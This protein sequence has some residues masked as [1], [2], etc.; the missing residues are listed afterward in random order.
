MAF[1]ELPRLDASGDNTMIILHGLLGSSSNWRSVAV[2]LQ[3]R[4]RDNSI[5][6]FDLRNHGSSPHTPSMTVKD[7]AGDIIRY[8]DSRQI[9]TATVVGHSLG[10]KAAMSSALLYSDRIKRLVVVDIA[11]VSYNSKEHQQWDD[12]NQI[13]NAMAAVPLASVSSRDQADRLLSAAIPDLT[14][15]R[16]VLQNLVS[17]K[18][19]TSGA[20]RWKWRVNIPVIQHSLDDLAQWTTAG[21]YEGEALFLAGG[22]S[23]YVIPAYMP[24]TRSFFPNAQFQFIE[25]AGHWVHADSPQGVT[26]AIM[27][28][29]AESQE[30]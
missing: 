18:S 30:R 11:P 9:A 4:L 29:M 14:T 10:G 24:T 15:R 5:V 22:R 25:S 19:E 1:Q 6:C 12:V 28:F 3:K 23:R 27:K 7:I 17:T 26:D 13:V 20:V 16:F 8:L 2:A 21:R